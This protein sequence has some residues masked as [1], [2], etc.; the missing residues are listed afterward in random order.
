MADRPIDPSPHPELVGDR[1]FV[2]S[3]ATVLGRVRLGNDSSVWFGAVIR[4]DTEWVEIGER[5]NIQDLSVL[6]ADP[7]YPCL[8]GN[9]VT[10]GHA[11]VVHGATVRDGALI[12][13]R[14]VVLNGAVIGSGAI[15]GAGSVV[16]EGREIPPGHLAVGVPARV[17]RELSDDDR[18]RI[19]ETADHYVQAAKAYRK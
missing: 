3:S 15:V 7:G 11:A 13:I 2:A 5:S 10:V 19:K 4:G 1:V 14:A 17:I 8:I 18:R 12:G 16:P 6:H 9:G